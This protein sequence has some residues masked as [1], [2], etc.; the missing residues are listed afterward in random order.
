MP[1]PTRNTPIKE[2]T[3][4][5]ID[6]GKRLGDDLPQLLA[7]GYGQSALPTEDLRWKTIHSVC[8]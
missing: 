3:L 4:T 2:A 8:N 1:S 7:T 5:A 6:P